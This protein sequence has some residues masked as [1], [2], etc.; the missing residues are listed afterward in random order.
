[1]PIMHLSG[2]KQGHHREDRR[3]GSSEALT[4][5]ASLRPTGRVTL[6]QMRERAGVPLRDLAKRVGVSTSTL[7]KFEAGI[8]DLAPATY[9]HTVAALQDLD[10][11]SQT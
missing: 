10:A 1:M 4:R 8:P 9:A 2:N 3:G 11:R 6:R 5:P 7:R